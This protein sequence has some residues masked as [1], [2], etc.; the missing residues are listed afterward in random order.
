[1][2]IK[3]HEIIIIIYRHMALEIN[4]NIIIIVIKNKILVIIPHHY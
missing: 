3:L 4:Y 2:V 1:M